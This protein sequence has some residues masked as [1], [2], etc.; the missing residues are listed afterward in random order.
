MSR[1]AAIN[2]PG[3]KLPF[4]KKTSEKRRR[5]PSESPK[6]LPMYSKRAKTYAARA[7][8]R[9]EEEETATP[10]LR[11]MSA[12]EQEASGIKFQVKKLEKAL[13]FDTFTNYTWR[14]T[15]NG[16]FDDFVKALTCLGKKVEN[17]AAKID[18]VKKR[19]EKGDQCK[20]MEE[21]K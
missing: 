16:C 2:L 20:S 17:N 14:K 9:R 18:E 11:T 13:T 6:V 7:Q 21:K 1:S 4:T 19:M 15:I 5:A 10:K 3:P 8:T 12:S